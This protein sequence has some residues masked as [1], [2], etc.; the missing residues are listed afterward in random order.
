M[1]ALQTI[2]TNMD[3]RNPNGSGPLIRAKLVDRPEVTRKLTLE[4]VTV[5]S[6]IGHRLILCARSLHNYSLFTDLMSS[7]VIEVSGSDC[8]RIFQ[9]HLAKI[10]MSVSAIIWEVGSISKALGL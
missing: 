9:E 4:R 3:P 5:G 6:K 10:N 7:G 2:Y 8:C 1:D